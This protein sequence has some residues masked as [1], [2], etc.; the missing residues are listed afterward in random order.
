M[1]SQIKIEQVVRVYS[2]RPGCAC[3]CNGNYIDAPKANRVFSNMLK[4]DAANP[5]AK[6]IE[7]Y[8]LDG[9]KFLSLE[10]ETK[11]YTVYYK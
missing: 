5:E 1:L 11:V 3:G 4:F 7:G 2:G 6:K 10:I 8:D 9:D